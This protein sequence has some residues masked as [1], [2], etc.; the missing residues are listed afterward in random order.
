MTA[1]P[2]PRRF[3]ILLVDDS[4]HDARLT[5][6]AF[7]DAHVSHD[8][9]SARDGEAALQLLR[10]RDCARPDLILLDLNLPGTT[11]HEVLAEIKS[12]PQLCSIPVIILTVSSAAEDIRSAYAN[13]ANAY[14]R[15][16]LDLDRFLT[17][18]Q[19]TSDFWLTAVTLP[20]SSPTQPITQHA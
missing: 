16:S 20:P 2:R 12:D 9:H 1:Q 17:V 11:G 4:L 8:L 13:H 7:D 3:Q 6:E 18:V 10:R 5:R 19:A 14:I 15:K